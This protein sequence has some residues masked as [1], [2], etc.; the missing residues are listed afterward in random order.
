MGK[1]REAVHRFLETWDGKLESRKPFL[2]EN[3]ISPRWFN[4]Y[5]AEYKKVDKK[6]RPSEEQRIVNV[7]DVLY[8][9][10]VEDRNTDA[11]KTF[12]QAKGVF[13][14]KKGKKVEV[15]ADDYFRARDEALRRVSG[16]RVL[17]G[18]SLLPSEIRQNTGHAEGDNTVGT[19]GASTEVS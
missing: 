12:L 5:R 11:A 10:A 18:H 1:K 3:R 15:N 17:S 9:K 6:R 2:K 19:V 13:V 7:L 4:T 8:D 16:D 14:E